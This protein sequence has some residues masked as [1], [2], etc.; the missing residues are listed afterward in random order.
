[1]TELQAFID[2]G[3]QIVPIPDEVQP[4]IEDAERRIALIRR[5]IVG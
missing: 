1:M 3:R 4:A 5:Q 2:F